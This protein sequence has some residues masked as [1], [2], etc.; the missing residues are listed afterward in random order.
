M[1]FRIVLSDCL[2]DADVVDGDD[3]PAPELDVRDSGADPGFGCLLRVGRAEEDPA[4]AVPCTRAEN[5]S[6]GR[7]IRVNAFF[8]CVDIPATSRPI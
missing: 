3:R 7:I 8:S 1:A 2:A 4:A 5:V 6:K